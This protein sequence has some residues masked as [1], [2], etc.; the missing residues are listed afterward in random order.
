MKMKNFEL[1]KYCTPAQLYLVIGVIFIISCFFENYSIEMLLT[2]ALF[3][4]IWAWVLNWLC[5]KG[6]KTISWIIVLLPF[7]F[8]LFIYFL[9]KDLL[10]VREGIDPGC[11][12][13]YR[14]GLARVKYGYSTHT[15]CVNGENAKAAAAASAAAAAEKKRLAD[16]AAALKKKQ[17]LEAAA[18]KA[19]ADAEAKA[20]A[21]AEAKAK[22]DAVAAETK[23][24]ADEAT[25]LEQK[26]LADEAAALE[27]KRLAALEEKRRADEAVAAAKAKADAEV[28]EAKAKADA[29]KKKADA[30]VAEAKAKA[31]AAKKKADA[32]AQACRD[33]RGKQLC[34]IKN[35]CK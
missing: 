7:V 22:A 23:R 14:P 21:D 24:K 11:G 31:D 9:I 19:K 20:K 10:V 28:A 32:A 17:A 30:E 26:R 16:E 13:L 29:A 15:E 3:L 6:F 4:V 18:A 25:A 2:Q 12:T 8:F 27:Q 34:L 5:S 35:K 33:C 1:S